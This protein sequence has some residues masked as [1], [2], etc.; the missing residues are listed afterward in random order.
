VHLPIVRFNDKTN[1]TRWK[2]GISH[3]GSQPFEDVARKRKYSG[4]TKKL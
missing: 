2:T 3:A 4:N 1:V